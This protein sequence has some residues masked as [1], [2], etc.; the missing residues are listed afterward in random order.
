MD[1]VRNRPLNDFA[2]VDIDHR[3]TFS[4]PLNMKAKDVLKYL[5]DLRGISKE[6]FISIGTEFA[7]KTWR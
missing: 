3:I 6:V 2:L 4:Q 7:H 1:G 5:K